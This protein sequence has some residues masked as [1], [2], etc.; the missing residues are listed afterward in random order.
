M[1]SLTAQNLIDQLSA[2]SDED[3]QLPVYLY[4]EN[5]EEMERVIC[6]KIGR[7]NVTIEDVKEP[8][9]EDSGSYNRYYCKGF[10]PMNEGEV[11]RM[12]VIC[13]ENIYGDR[14]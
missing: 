14:D 1:A 12:V 4:L 8:M 7:P 10:H 5:T 11:E 2:L 13:S 9:I 3:K 6:T